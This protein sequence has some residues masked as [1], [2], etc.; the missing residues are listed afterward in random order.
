MNETR[1][2]IFNHQAAFQ[3]CRLFGGE[4]VGDR[5]VMENGGVLITPLMD[6]TERGNVWQ[7][8]TADLPEGASVEWRF[9]ATDNERTADKI[10]GLQEDRALDVWDVLNRLGE[11]EEFRQFGALDFIPSKLRGQ[12]CV[13]AVI[14]TKPEGTPPL[15]IRSIQVYSAW[16]SFLP[17]LP[18]IYREEGGFLDR[19][20]RL[21]SAPYLEL[22]QKTDALYETLDPRAASPSR[23]R[24]LA[25]AMGIPH[26]ELWE[27]ENL[28]GLLMSGL[29]R[30]KG[31]FSALAD[32]VTQYTGFRPYVCENFRML[33]GDTE[34]DRHY[35]NGEITLLL[36]PEASGT[37]VNVTNL[38]TVLRTFLPG[39]VSCAI[40]ILQM[41]P[42]LSDSSY[43]GINTRLGEYT[44]AELGVNS[45]LNF[46]LLGD[47]HHGEYKPVSSQP[48]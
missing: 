36:P 4:I 9:Y 15:V 38:D 28:R 11:F 46:A 48:Q 21:F 34:T 23:V 35:Q 27:T 13:T 42:A 45:R 14:F 41:H 19:F 7:R 16:E 12:F 31:R 5:V 1:Y 17:Y 8:V 3:R 44:A 33:T 43:L 39:G 24:W 30:K 37:E 10:R 25:E 47:S 20:L 18:E 29:Y 6:S 26:I 22:E 2:F 40:R 32:F